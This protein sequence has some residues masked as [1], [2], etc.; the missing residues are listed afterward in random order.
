MWTISDTDLR[1]NASKG[2]DNI[3]A[4]LMHRRLWPRWIPFY[5]SLVYYYC[6]ITKC[7]LQKYIW[8]HLIYL[9]FF[10]VTFIANRLYL[11]NVRVSTQTTIFPWTLTRK[12][13][14]WGTLWYHTEINLCAIHKIGFMPCV[15]GEI[16]VHLAVSYFNPNHNL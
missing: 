3:P 5:L 13:H 11:T 6:N 4:D 10:L 2:D 7:I 8:K 12:L 9:T 14:V 15:R 1:F 16:I